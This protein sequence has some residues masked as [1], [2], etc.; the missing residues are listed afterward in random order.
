MAALL[1]ITTQGTYSNSGT[2]V[3][4]GIDESN[5]LH[6]SDASF[7]VQQSAANAGSAIAGVGKLD[8]SNS[9]NT[10][11]GTV[12]MSAVGMNATLAAGTNI[13]LGTVY[14]QDVTV[15][16]TQN[17]TQAAGSLVQAD[18]L[19][20]QNAQG[21]VLNN[22]N[23]VN[24]LAASGL[25]GTLSFTDA[26]SLS[27][28]TASA[29]DGIGSSGSVVLETTTGDLVLTKAI[30]VSGGSDITLASAGNFINNVG[31]NAF[32][33]GTGNWQVWSTDP[34]LDTVNGLSPN[35]KQYDA[36]YGTSTVLGS[37][38]GALYTLAPQLT[39][40]LTGSAARAYDAGVDATL[41]QG[42]YGVTGLVGSDAVVLGTSGTFDN[43]NVGSGK[44]VMV[45]PTI[46]SASDGSIQ[47]YGYQIDSGSATV[48]GA[49][50]TITPATISAVTGITA[51]NKTYD[52]NTSATL[53]TSSTVGFTGLFSGDNLTVA[54]A[55]GTFASP[56]ASANPIAVSVTGITLGGTDAGNYT[57]STPTAST[58][59]SIAPYAVS[60]TGTRTYDGTTTVGA[61]ALT[62]GP[63]VGSETL[64]LSGSGVASSKNVG[65]QTVG[66]SGLTLADGT[67]LAS[68]PT[69]FTGG[70]DTVDITQAN[71]TVTP[72]NVSK[73]YDGSL[74]ASGTAVVAGGTQLFGGD[75]LSGGTYAFTN[76]N[77]GTGNKTVTVSGVTVNDGDSGG[78]YNVSYVS[79]ATST[80]NPASITVDA[81]NITKTYDGTLTANGT[82]NLVS[83]ALYHNASNGNAQDTLGG[84]TFAFTDPNAGSGNKAVTTSGV[85]VNDGNSGG[86]YAV[87]YVHSLNPSF[88]QPGP[89]PNTVCE[90]RY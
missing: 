8:L 27:V 53:N 80:I 21:V 31:A 34:S 75:S 38:N 70:T 86:N 67:G 5:A 88:A 26:Q 37:G 28:G 54:S 32:T 52:G 44:T 61:G 33:L 20:L 4:T 10:F 55:T 25:T 11:G 65:T 63:L 13:N 46:V 64:T 49:I 40:S 50:G 19:L 59:A 29:V 30:T 77:A 73:T 48:S 12:S 15:S 89:R 58:S 74:S 43:K 87:T 45:N 62:L 39:V 57:L 9:G 41:T 79:N 68:N 72:S 7:T 76:A 2:A 17:V 71:L 1:K 85:T 24:T 35:F 78:N 18:T 84:G 56:N 42:N 90:F 3:A 69:T 82:A 47:V 81:A 83:G 14:A 60:L 16:T 22:A 51:A 66:V 23:L 36:T 6:L